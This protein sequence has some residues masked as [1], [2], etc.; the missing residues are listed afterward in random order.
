MFDS[1]KKH[2]RPNYMAWSNGIKL[3]TINGGN[4]F[5]NSQMLS[6]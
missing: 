1:N 6:W 3:T 2:D 5:D 4:R